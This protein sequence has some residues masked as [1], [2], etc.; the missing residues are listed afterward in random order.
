MSDPKN[1]HP[2]HPAGPSTTATVTPAA[3]RTATIP[4]VVQARFGQPVSWAGRSWGIEPTP[5]DAVPAEVHDLLR[6]PPSLHVQWPEDFVAPDGS[7]PGKRKMATHEASPL[8][9]S[10]DRV[11]AAEAQ[12][13]SALTTAQATETAFATYRSKA[14]AE[15]GELRRA[16]EEQTARAADLGTQVS[17][18]T[19]TST[20]AK[21][22]A[23]AQ[24][25]AHAQQIEALNAQHRGE[26][27]T[28]RAQHETALNALTLAHEAKLAESVAMVTELTGELEK[29]TSPPKAPVAVGAVSAAALGEQAASQTAAEIKAAAKQAKADAK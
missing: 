5:H 6:A 13:K 26:L 20:A 2:A 21:D 24:A 8:L 22:A 9:T 27:D 10:A 29:L 17:G 12:A 16:L 7:M 18:S 1:N 15:T 11:A 19:L 4:I 23:E 25:K 14:E 3:K 28:L